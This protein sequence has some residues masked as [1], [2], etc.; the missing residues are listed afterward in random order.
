MSTEQPVI[1]LTPEEVEQAR[2]KAVADK[3]AAARA[4]AD[5][6]ALVDEHLQAMWT[7]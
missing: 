7:K 6:L 5:A 2:L 1:D 3:E 4:Q